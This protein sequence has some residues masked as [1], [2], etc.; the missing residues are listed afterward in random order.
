MAHSEIRTGT[1]RG[2]RIFQIRKFIADAIRFSLGE[3]GW[4]FVG[5]EIQRAIIAAK[6]AHV[7]AGQDESI[8]FTSKDVSKLL[9]SMLADCGLDE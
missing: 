3:T 2:F 6:V 9:E 7:F 1:D 4:Y 5:P 8:V